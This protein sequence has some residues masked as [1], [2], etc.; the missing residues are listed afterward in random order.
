MLPTTPRPKYWLDD[1]VKLEFTSLKQTFNGAIKLD[2]GQGG[3]VK[4]VNNIKTPVEKKKKDTLEA[5]IE[6]VNEKYAGDFTDS[7]RVII[8]GIL[9]MFMND[10]EIKKYKKY[11]KDNDP[12]VFVKSLFPDKFKDIVT[13][14]F[15][16]NN[17][18]FKKLFND[19]DFYAKVMEAM[20]KELYKELREE[21]K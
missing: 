12:E 3:V 13:K 6:K 10:D 9:N 5:I 8:S 4:P 11:A 2:E 17:D 7:D 16:E 15:L 20:A 1:K 21:K 18:T 19:S 14:C